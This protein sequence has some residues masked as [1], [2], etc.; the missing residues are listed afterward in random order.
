M[1]AAQSACLTKLGQDIAVT[2]KQ[3]MK[4]DAGLH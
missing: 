3:L 1:V 2:L 4:V